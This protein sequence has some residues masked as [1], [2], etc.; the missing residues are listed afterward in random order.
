MVI[1]FI[2]IHIL[3]HFSLSTSQNKKLS[4]VKSAKH[5]SATSTDIC[6]LNTL[7]VVGMLVVMVTVVMVFTQMVGLV[8]SVVLVYHTIYSV[9]NVGKDI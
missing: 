6:A 8:V 2:L 4:P 5:Q 3:I 7:V 1:C 9:Q